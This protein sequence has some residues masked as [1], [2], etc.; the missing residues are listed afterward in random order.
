MGDHEHV[1]LDEAVFWAYQDV[2]VAARCVAE[3]SRAPD[4]LVWHLAR[5]DAALDA[6]LAASKA[7]PLHHEALT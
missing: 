5:L 7:D 2:E 1:T 6:S 4:S 3:G